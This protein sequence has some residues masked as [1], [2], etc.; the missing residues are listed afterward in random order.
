M[1]KNSMIGKAVVMAM[2]FAFMASVGSVS[3][4]DSITGT[5]HQS[6]S[7]EVRIKAE[8]GADYIVMGA[9]ITEM[10]GKTVKATGTLS[11][12]GNVKIIE[13]MSMEE[14]IE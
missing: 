5:I 9:D 10:V 11:E 14:V 7:G 13:V 4:E 12:E 2:V 6:D 8:D 1:E 3:A